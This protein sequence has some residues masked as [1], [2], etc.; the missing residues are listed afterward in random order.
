MSYTYLL[1]LYQALDERIRDLTVE[2]QQTSLS[3][4]QRAY[5]QGRLDCLAAFASFLK[6]N[7]H[8]KLPRRI[9]KIID[10]R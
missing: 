7:Y 2:Q 4:E 9:Q 8:N 5:L 6:N 10:I 1:E 3:P